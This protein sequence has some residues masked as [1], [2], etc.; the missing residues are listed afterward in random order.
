MKSL[1]CGLLTAGLLS[2]AVPTWAQEEVYSAP[3]YEQQYTTRPVSR[4]FGPPLPY[5]VYRPVY[6][7]YAHGGR[8]GVGYVWGFPWVVGGY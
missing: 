7:P 8:Q 1:L 3:V 4:A 6:R 2:V 5:R